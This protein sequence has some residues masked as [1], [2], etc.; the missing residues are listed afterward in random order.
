MNLSKFKSFLF[1]D[2]ET[3]SSNDI[4][5]GVYSYSSSKDYELLL[6]S[7]SLNGKDVKTFSPLEEDYPKEFITALLDKNTAKVAHNA[8]FERVCL[9]KSIYKEN[10]KYFDPEEWF[11]TMVMASEIG[12]PKSLNNLCEELN[13]SKEDKKE[14]ALG[15]RLI[16]F[17]SKPVNPTKSNNYSNRNYPEVDEEKWKLYKFY[18][19]KDVKA[20]IAVWTRLLP[21]AEFITDKEKELFNLDARINDLGV[22]IDKEFVD[23][24]LEL[25]N[26]ENEDAL[27]KLKELTGLDNPNSRNQLLGYLNAIPGFENVNSLTKETVSELVEKIKNSKDPTKEN[28]LQILRLIQGLKKTSNAKYEAMNESSVYKESDK[29]YRV[30]GMLQFYGASRTGRWAGRIV[31]LQ[32]LPR[33]SIKNIEIVRN[34]IK[35]KDFDTIELCYSNLSQIV[36][37]LIRTS[38]IP[39]DNARFIVCD[40]NAIESRVAA[41]VA[42]EKWKLKAFIEGKGIYEETA[43]KMFKVPTSEITHDS[44]LRAK[45]KV[46]ELAGQYQGGLGAYKAMGADKLGL[47]DEEILD[48]VNSWRNEN[49]NIV[50][51]WNVL[52]DNIRWLVLTGQKLGNQKPR[53]IPIGINGSDKL[54]LIYKNNSLYIVLPSKRAIVYQ[55]CIVE[56]NNSISYLGENTARKRERLSAYG[57]KFF[58][59]IVQAIARDCLADAM[60][61]LEKKGFHV[62]FHVHDEVVISVDYSAYRSDAKAIEAIGNIMKDAAGNYGSKIPLKAAGYS[63]SFYLKD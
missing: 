3:F 7:Y 34:C 2:I 27:N 15:T 38:F 56:S 22:R 18:N 32:N 40:Y 9:S 31:Q 24:V 48:L 42:N 35:S 13:I 43:S 37:E 30:H 59:N 26:K 11:C 1:L 55:Q 25:M 21:Q 54:K 10:N 58:E 60:L 52:E 36:S 41:W 29:T 50:N 20:L 47:S 63:C 51:M 57:G 19:S 23:S 5:R 4:T 33:N 44:P 28:V 62:N 6:C 12:L 8:N 16:S 61:E 46:A 17:F 39:N 14:T 45:G 49:K 53:I